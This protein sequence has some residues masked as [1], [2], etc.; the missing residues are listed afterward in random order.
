V[1]K[2]PPEADPLLKQRLAE[3]L[4]EAIMEGRLTSGERVVEGCWA[5][6]YG[7]AQASVREAI[8]LLV[9]EGFLVKNAGRSARVPRYTRDDV[10]RIYQVRGALEGLAGRLAAEAHADLA[11]L[12]AAVAKMEHA[13]ACGDV[14]SLISADL[15]FHLELASA[16]GNALLAETLTRLLSPLFAFVLLRMRQTNEPASAWAPDLVRHREII[17]LIQDSHPMIA[18]QFV[19]HCVGQFVDSG[20][21][22]W[23]PEP[24]T[25]RR[26]RG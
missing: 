7:V 19:E 16:S 22:V 9:A 24:E 13:A 11:P 6:E 17:H 3:R 25:K 23:W 12:E 4:R 14:P 20:R 21:V 8:N 2:Q 10:L 15:E 1:P 18:A 26:E 5:R